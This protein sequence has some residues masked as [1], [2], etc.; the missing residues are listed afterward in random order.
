M[1]FTSSLLALALSVVAVATFSG[2]G[3][4][5]AICNPPCGSG[6]ECGF[7]LNDEPRCLESC[8]GSVCQD[9]QTCQNGT[10]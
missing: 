9:N 1:R 7:D 5:L 6:F 8:G 10:C 2:C 4:D 3:D